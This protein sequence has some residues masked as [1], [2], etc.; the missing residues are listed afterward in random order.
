MAKKKPKKTN[1]YKLK[2]ILV[3]LTL[4][5]FN[6]IYQVYKK[7][8]E[9]FRPFESLLIKSP[10]ETW[11]NYGEYFEAFAT[12]RV[13]ASFLAALAQVESAGNPWANSFWKFR[14]TTDLDRI[15]SPAS[16]AVGL[17]QITEPTMKEAQ[18]FCFKENKKVFRGKCWEDRFFTRL[19]PEHSIELTSARMEYY[20]KKMTPAKLSRRNLEKL[21]S[22]FHL[23][24]VN[25]AKV[26]QR[27][28]Y[29]FSALGRCG[30]HRP[31]KYYQKINRMKA[32]FERI[33][34]TLN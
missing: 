2:L 34:S 11:K 18:N 7:P 4:P 12:H 14:W 30:Y 16:T 24:G 5:L 3:L 27:S 17:L 22:V 6:L 26:F 20:L 15:Y 1:S 10:K 19:S 29:N 32:K 9:V 33:R 25:K 21:A 13:S 8:T 31:R 23:C 28:N